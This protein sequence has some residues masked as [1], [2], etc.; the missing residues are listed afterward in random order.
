[1]STLKKHMTTRPIPSLFISFLLLSA[2]ATQTD[3]PVAVPAARVVADGKLPFTVERFTLPGPV[4]GVVVKVDLSDPRVAVKVALA[5]DRDPDGN[6][7]CVG[8]LDTTS[9]AAKRHDFDVTLN[10][11]FFAAPTS[12][13]VL[14]RKIRYFVG[15]C[16]FPEGWHFSGG[17][18]VSKPAKDGLRSTIIVHASGKISIGDDVRELPADTRYAVSGSATVLRAGVPIVSAAVAARHPRSAVGLSADGSTLVMLAVDGRQ[19]TA[20]E[21][22]YGRAHSR[23]A[24]LQEL[25]ELMR[26]FGA[27]DAINLDGGGS[28]AMVLKDP[29]T[30]VFSIANQPSD[31]STLKLP[32]AI[33]RPVADVIGITINRGANAR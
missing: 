7:P 14:G 10:A 11:S 12:K 9:S 25:G 16:T 33:E 18:L 20:A 24:T 8:V 32:V 23:G 4:A 19:A 3:A 26:G 28:T 29:Y 27:A 1:M 5:D 13:E 31:A 6:G 21:S 30:G 22:P 17:K 2:C 15:N